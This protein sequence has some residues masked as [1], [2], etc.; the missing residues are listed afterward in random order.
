MERRKHF[1]DFYH[2]IGVRI[3]RGESMSESRMQRI[4]EKWDK[5]LERNRLKNQAKIE[6]KS[7]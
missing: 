1:I 2:E 5:R 4:K 7:N 3:S 6:V